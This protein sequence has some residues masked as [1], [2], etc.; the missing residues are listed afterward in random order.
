MYLRA[1][2]LHPADMRLYRKAFRHCMEVEDYANA[3][4]VCNFWIWDFPSES[5]STAEVGNM[6]ALSF[7]CSEGNELCVDSG[8]HPK[9]GGFDG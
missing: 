2:R 4:A 9:G 6:F 5:R 1:L 3:E 7:Y 8:V